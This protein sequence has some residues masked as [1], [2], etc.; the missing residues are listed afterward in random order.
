MTSSST[1][2]RP[3]VHSGPFRGLGGLTLAEVRRWLPARAAG[4]TIAGLVVMVA[5]YGFF[6]LIVALE[7]SDAGLGLF[8]Y[9]FIAIWAIVLTLTVLAA[10]Q[11][12]VAGEIDDGTAAW[13]TGMPVSRS[14]FI[15]SKVLAAVPGLAVAV[16]GTGVVGYFLIRQAASIQTTDF[17]LEKLF[18]AT[19]GTAGQDVWRS[20]PEFGEYLGLLVRLTWFELF[21]VA[22]LALIGTFFRSRSAVLGLGLVVAIAMLVFGLLGE[23]DVLGVD[24]DLAPAGLLAGSFDVLADESAALLVPLVATTVWIVALTAAATFRFSRKEL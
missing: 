4:L 3:V 18:D 20:P 6:R 12:A 23:Q 1:D 24:L 10:A 16:A 9:P 17:P 15:V 11:G 21:L 7:P 2:L 19:R 22:T 14:S 8:L 5:F 13:L